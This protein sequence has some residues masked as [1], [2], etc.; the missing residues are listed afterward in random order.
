M[1][2]ETLEKIKK[3]VLAFRHGTARYW[4]IL[5]EENEF[6][7]FI[8]VHNLQE[9]EIAISYGVRPVY[10]RKGI[11]SS[12]LL[13]LLRWEGIQ[14]KRIVLTTHKENEASFNMLQKLN[15][16]YKG[17]KET[18]MGMRHVFVC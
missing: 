5:T 8:A 1:E 9:E 18:G 16:T 11:A 4:Y 6:A 13:E 15:L 12:A 7:G 2:V 17:L 14:H 3:N 10:R